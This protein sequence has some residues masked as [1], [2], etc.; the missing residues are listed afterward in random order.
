[1][2][3]NSNSNY[4]NASG[5][6]PP[7]Q[8][9]PPNPDGIVPPPRT[10]RRSTTQPLPTATTQPLASGAPSPASSYSNVSGLPPMSAA[11]YSSQSP[12]TGTTPSSSYSS[13]A[14]LT[15]ASQQQ[16]N[17]Y[18][19]Q[20]GAI[21]PRT[22]ST[23]QSGTKMSRSTS[24]MSRKSSY[25]DLA[26]VEAGSFS[27]LPPDQQTSFGSN[28]KRGKS[29]V[30]YER[31]PSE[32]RPPVPG[33][34][35]AVLSDGPT[36]FVIAEPSPSFANGQVPMAAAPRPLSMNVPTAQ[37]M[38]ISGQVSNQQGQGQ[39]P[40]QQQV[41]GT[42]PMSQAYYATPP[43]MP[44]SQ[45]ASVSTL[46]PLQVAAAASIVGNGYGQ[47]SSPI[48]Q[49]TLL[50]ERPIPGSEPQP[51]RTSS[52]AKSVNSPDDSTK[53][54]PLT[55][56]RVIVMILTFW[57][58]RPLL[59]CCGLKTRDQ[60]DAWREKVALVIIILLLCTAVGFLTFGF[61]QTVCGRP[62]P[63]IQGSQLAAAGATAIHGRGIS[64]D[65]YTHPVSQY[66]A[67][68]LWTWSVGR[69]IGFL[70]PPFPEQSVC[71]K[72]LGDNYTHWP[73][74]IPGVWPR[75][76]GWVLIALDMIIYL[77]FRKADSFSFSLF[78]RTLTAKSRRATTPK[79]PA[80]W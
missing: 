79:K 52:K 73:C 45:Q 36:E 22:D 55:W 76:A 40:Q 15:P 8:Q 19:Q 59:S 30:K 37:M 7:S 17:Y 25:N 43:S 62:A 50:G 5:G 1:M 27:D 78:A 6:R 71:R 38:Q 14:L 18:S 42:R 51:P 66:G 61:T 60:Q 56:W 9:Q 20:P 57:A 46:P 21:P 28:I 64:T 74:T 65:G 67:I 48:Q 3:S 53:G 31:A 23:G 77:D 75:Q 13:S 44:I 72:V 29:L 58:I 12:A 32:R 63:R 54:P 34:P 80:T 4:S 35:H 16:P 24:N 70:F 68:D 33:Q 49:G 47:A 2:S 41:V 39:L 26:N 69:D 11:S 10:Y